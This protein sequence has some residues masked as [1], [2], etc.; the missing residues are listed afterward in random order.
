MSLIGSISFF[1]KCNAENKMQL[2][3][4]KNK[5]T[6]KIKKSQN[7]GKISFNLSPTVENEKINF[8]KKQID[9]ILIISTDKSK[10]G[11]KR[12]KW[13]KFWIHY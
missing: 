13:S 4:S 7:L 9:N 11:Q 12:K 10:I 1:D 8:D 6:F 2:V 3:G 5:L